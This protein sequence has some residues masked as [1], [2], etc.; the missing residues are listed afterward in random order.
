MRQLGVLAVW[1]GATAAT[2]TVGWLLRSWARPA[3]GGNELDDDADG[4]S[5]DDQDD[6][7][8]FR[9]VELDRTAL[10][11]VLGFGALGYEAW[12][13]A[14]GSAPFRTAALVGV[15]SGGLL[16]ASLRD[17]PERA[18]PRAPP[19]PVPSVPEPP[20]P[21]LRVPTPSAGSVGDLLGRTDGSTTDGAPLP[22]TPEQVEDDQS[23]GEGSDDAPTTDDAP[24]DSPL[25][26]SVGDD[27]DTRD[28]PTP[29]AVSLSDGDPDNRPD[30]PILFADGAGESRECRNC[31]TAGDVRDTRVATVPDREAEQVPLCDDCRIA[32]AAREDDPDAC[33]S[34]GRRVASVGGED[35]RC[36]NCGYIGRLSA[37][38]IVPLDDGGQPHHANA[39]ALCETCHAAAHG[40]R[41]AELTQ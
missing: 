41:E 8:P 2:V 13:R 36:D 23:A 17:H 38:A 22:A 16:V 32:A 28:A 21:T 5:A 25:R 14:A 26:P 1:L 12:G 39:V 11:A 20:S 37:H 10:L 7:E 33:S 35:G 24:A 34:V 31:G 3:T 27:G 40:R 19:V 18:L 15:L 30:G 9:A 6:V 29:T 4:A